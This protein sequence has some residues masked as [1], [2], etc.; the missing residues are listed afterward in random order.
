MLESNRNSE[1][2]LPLHSRICSVPKGMKGRPESI[3]DVSL[4][5]SDTSNR[6]SVLSDLSV[7][8]FK[9]VNKEHMV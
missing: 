6:V 9:S 1:A 8:P 3:E 7:M 2:L 4:I 5:N